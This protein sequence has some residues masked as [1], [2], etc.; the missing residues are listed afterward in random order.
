[1]GGGAASQAKLGLCFTGSGK[2]EGIKYWI[3][4]Q[5]LVIRIIST[6]P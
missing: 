3:V 6:I 5:N 2:Q 4:L 1:M